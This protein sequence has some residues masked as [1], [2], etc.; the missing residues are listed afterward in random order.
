M[1]ESIDALR[2]AN[3]RADATFVDSVGAV[4]RTVR[5]RLGTEAAS[6]RRSRLRWRP[7]RLSLAVAACAGVVAAVVSMSVGPSGAPNAAAAVRKAATVSAASAERSGIAVVR[8]THRGELWAETTIR[9]HG[10]DL[11]VSSDAPTRLGRPGSKLLVVGG[12]LYGI[13]P[14]HGGWMA[15]GSPS[16]LDPGSGATPAEYLAA[17]R[18]D[19][20]GATLERITGAMASPTSRQLADGSTVY[21]GAVK[22]GLIARE[23]GFKGG[24]AIRVLPFGFV[25]HGEA[26]DPASPLAASVTVGADGIVREI[27]VTWRTWSY[28]VRYDDL[29]ATAPL[30]APANASSLEQLRRK[31]AGR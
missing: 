10:D 24:Q 22:A 3:P 8:L 29:G 18:E 25:A 2:R 23:T 21:S 28:G 19:V 27:A 6:Q 13:E 31:R 11:S 17:V 12:T 7:V 16:N 30:V 14:E 5:T 4:G 20:G 26:A 9:W 15:M 1:S